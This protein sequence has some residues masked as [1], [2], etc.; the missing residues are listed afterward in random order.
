MNTY[1][2]ELSS[3]TTNYVEDLDPIN[4]EDHTSFTLNMENLYNGVIPTYVVVDWGDGT[5]ETFNNDI[6][7][8]QYDNQLK[9]FNY[10]PI[11]TDLHTHEYYP[12]ATSLYKDMTL[13]VLVHYSNQE[14]SYFSGDIRIRSYDLVEA[15]GHMT[16]VNVNILDNNLQYQITTTPGLIEMTVPLG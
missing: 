5:V 9:F 10:N 16:P 4:L 7:G 14:E 15:V 2:L 6:Y 3:N 8:T 13:Q 11:F 12:S 1:T